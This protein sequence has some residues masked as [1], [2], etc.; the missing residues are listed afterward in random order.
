[1]SRARVDYQAFAAEFWRFG[2]AGVLGFFADAG[3]LTVLVSVLHW[4]L[5]S[6]RAVSFAFAVTVTWYLNR[7]WTFARHASVS[8]QREYLNYVTVQTAGAAVNLGVYSGVIELVPQFRA[9]P[10]IPLA[11][12]SVVAMVFNFLASRRFVFSE[13]QRAQTPFRN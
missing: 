2:Q 7:R 6:G 9:F 11:I 3:V 1:M 5:Y 8:R 10:V 12:G 4:G 13:R